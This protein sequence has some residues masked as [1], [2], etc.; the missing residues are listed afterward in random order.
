MEENFLFS[1]YLDNGYDDMDKRKTQTIKGDNKA[2]Q[3]RA[4][5]EREITKKNNWMALIIIHEITND[6]LSFKQ[7]ALS[8]ILSIALLTLQ[9]S[10]L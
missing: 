3:T 5:R 1:T 2:I 10:C 6:T 8:M 9:L 7:R 4:K